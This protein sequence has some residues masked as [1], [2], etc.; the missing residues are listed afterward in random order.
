MPVFAPPVFTPRLSWI[1]AMPVFAPSW[2][3][4]MPVFARLDRRNACLRSL[5]SLAVFLSSL[6]VFA[7]SAGRQRVALERGD[8]AQGQPLPKIVLA[9]SDWDEAQ[10]EPAR[11]ILPPVE[12]DAEGRFRVERLVPG[13][14][15]TAG[16]VGQE[17]VERGFGVVIDHV[18]L[19]A[20]ETRDLGDV[21]PQS[22]G[23]GADD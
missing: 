12:T 5:S 20:G 7:P 23:P 10:V 16:A 6:A 22:P 1:D 21:R 18:V 3:D 9:S 19:K 14:S 17:A 4:A 11:G 13:R 2:I 15:Y 8:D